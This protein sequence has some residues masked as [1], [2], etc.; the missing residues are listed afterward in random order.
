MAERA[1]RHPP[2]SAAVLN[3]QEKLTGFPARV[4]EN[5]AV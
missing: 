3:D 5:V 2:G 4:P 1:R